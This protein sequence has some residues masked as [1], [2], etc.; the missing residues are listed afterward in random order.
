M[1]R[2]IDPTLVLGI[3]I[4]PSILGI[5]VYGVD[6]GRWDVSD[7]QW[8]E[9]T[10]RFREHLGRRLG[11]PKNVLSL[12]QGHYRVLYEFRPENSQDDLE[13]CYVFGGALQAAED[14]AFSGLDH[15]KTAYFDVKILH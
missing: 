5:G 15:P 1:K 11:G 9:L 6:L 8:L 7:A 4:A 13:A 14:Y 2:R 3:E 10:Q 12:S